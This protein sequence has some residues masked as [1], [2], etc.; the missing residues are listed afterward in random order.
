MAACACTMGVNFA[1]GAESLVCVCVCV[2]QVVVSTAVIIAW[3]MV[4]IPADVGMLNN[5]VE[6]WRYNSAQA[7]MR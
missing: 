2:N 4:L 1:I 5:V 6:L 3:C 7:C